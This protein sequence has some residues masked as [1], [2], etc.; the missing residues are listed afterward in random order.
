VF[1]VPFLR[2][3]CG[4]GPI[5]MSGFSFFVYFTGKGAELE[6]GS[7]IAAPLGTNVS[8]ANFFVFAF[9]EGCADAAPPLFVVKFAGLPGLAVKNS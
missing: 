8:F 2:G 6:A 4:T 9:L 3:A 7:M 5:L 1:Y